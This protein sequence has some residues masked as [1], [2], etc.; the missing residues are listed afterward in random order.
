LATPSGLGGV[1]AIQQQ[2]SGKMAEREQIPAKREG[3]MFN[4]VVM[5]GAQGPG[6]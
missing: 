2:W 4:A 6:A 1:P 5:A 3:P